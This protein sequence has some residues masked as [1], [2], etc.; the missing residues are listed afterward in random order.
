MSAE[1]RPRYRPE[2]IRRIQEG[3]ERQRIVREKEYEPILQ[4]EEEPKQVYHEWFLQIFPQLRVTETVT[5]QRVNGWEEYLSPKQFTEKYGVDTSNIP[6]DAKIMY[7]RRVDDRIELQYQ[8]PTKTVTEWV[9]RELFTPRLEGYREEA[10]VGVTPVYGRSPFLDTGYAAGLV[11]LPI[12]L[13]EATI[14]EYEE[15]ILGKPTARSELMTKE[16]LA[17]TYGIILASIAGYKILPKAAPWILKKIGKTRPAQWLGYEFRAKAPKRLLGLVYG[18]KGAAIIDIER[19]WGWDWTYSE[20]LKGRTA[21]GR[22]AKAVWGTEAV[23]RTGIP[24]YRHQTLWGMMPTKEWEFIRW[25]QQEGFVEMPRRAIERQLKWSLGVSPAFGISAEQLMKEAARFPEGKHLGYPLKEK[26]MA[27]EKVTVY[28]TEKILRTS[29]EG[30]KLKAE[31]VSGWSIPTEAKTKFTYRGAFE[32][33]QATK[34]IMPSRLYVPKVSERA[35]TMAIKPIRGVPT[36]PFETTL[37]KAMMGGHPALIRQIMAK[38]VI[39]GIAMRMPLFE[40]YPTAPVRMGEKAR[41]RQIMR[42]FAITAQPQVIEPS[43]VMDVASAMGVNVAM[44]QMQRL[45]QAQIQRQ[46]LKQAQKQ[47]QELKKPRKLKLIVPP[48]FLGRPPPKRAMIPLQPMIPRER[49]RP[50]VKRKRKLSAFERWWLKKYPIPS[51][52]EVARRLR[53]RRKVKRRKKKRVPS[54]LR[55]SSAAAK[56]I[57]S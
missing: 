23:T 10:V 14:G 41:L 52:A 28:K 12:L 11:T 8:T 57:L 16:Q 44:M 37:K 53:E 15:Y 33:E 54:F 7:M 56:H 2:E 5:W 19:T 29:L 20:L 4:V 43:G 13:G 55:G 49:R 31:I 51:G 3:V 45:S 21:Y 26:M 50:R 17:V 30:S 34:M 24:F 22:A 42:Q 6:K 32:F 18:K 47:M 46:S 27:A 38:P 9:V 39:Y 35:L 1:A 48:I 36:T 40:G 25:L